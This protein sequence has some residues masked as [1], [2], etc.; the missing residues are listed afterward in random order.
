MRVEC[1]EKQQTQLAAACATAWKEPS[2]HSVVLLLGSAVTAGEKSQGHYCLPLT[3]TAYKNQ[4]GGGICY[5][6]ASVQYS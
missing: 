5:S 1:E 4:S 6:P 3:C 2:K